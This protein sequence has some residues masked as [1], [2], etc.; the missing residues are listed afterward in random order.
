MLVIRRMFRS[1]KYTRQVLFACLFAA[2]FFVGYASIAT[3]MRLWIVPAGFVA[4]VVFAMALLGVFGSFVRRGTRAMKKL[5]PNDGIVIYPDLRS[6]AAACAA[7]LILVFG[8]TERF[9]LAYFASIAAC[10]L[11]CSIQ[12]CRY[13]REEEV[14][15]AAVVQFAFPVIAPFLAVFVVC[16]TFGRKADS[17]MVVYYKERD[18]EEGLAQYME[19]VDAHRRQA[20]QKRSAGLHAVL[21]MSVLS[22]AMP[23]PE[24]REKLLAKRETRSDLCMA[25]ALL[26]VA[27]LIAV[28]LAA[29]NDSA[30]FLKNA[31]SKRV[32][33]QEEALQLERRI[34]DVHQKRAFLSGV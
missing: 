5:T 12:A 9:A 1:D 13:N 27:F 8:G 29:G 18:D 28:R 26:P 11:F 4:C 34:E 31:F 22:Y 23:D 2:C 6:F 14:L 3:L 30:L 7:V 16:M 10:V 25:L 21:A 24:E 19:E 33:V 15:L 17:R 20:Q 32:F